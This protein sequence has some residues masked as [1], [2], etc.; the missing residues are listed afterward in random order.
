MASAAAAP[1]ARQLAFS[2]PLHCDARTRRWTAGTPPLW[3]STWPPGPPA[4]PKEV[5]PDGGAL[6]VEAQAL[7]KSRLIADSNVPDG[8]ADCAWAGRMNAIATVAAAPM[9]ANAPVAVVA[10]S[11]TPLPH[12][13]EMSSGI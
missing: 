10:R 5:Q 4:T 11:R 6:V 8:A 12:P 2:S 13:I 7:G 3:T 9:P 1:A